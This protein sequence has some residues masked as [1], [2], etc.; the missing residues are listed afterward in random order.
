M[1]TEAKIGAAATIVSYNPATGEALAE[2]PCATLEEVRSAVQRAKDAQ[3]GWQATPI[4]QRIAVLRR[5]QEL[6][7]AQRDDVARLICREA[8]KPAAEALPPKSW[9]FST[10]LSFAYAIFTLSC[11]TALFLTP[12]WP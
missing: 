4:S 10:R 2:L 1:V 3:P 5:F 7:L 12:I 11:A 8:G 9:W 6:L